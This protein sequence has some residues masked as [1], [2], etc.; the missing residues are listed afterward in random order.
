MTYIRLGSNSQS[1]KGIIKSKKLL[2]I[3]LNGKRYSTE[4]K[5]NYKDIK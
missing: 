1:I 3:L 5:E 2:T 4:W